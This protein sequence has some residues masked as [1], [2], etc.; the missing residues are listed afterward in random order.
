MLLNGTYEI[1]GDHVNQD[2]GIDIS[3]IQIIET[4]IGFI[5]FYVNP[6]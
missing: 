6:Y 4:S 3:E 2:G 1:Y 5:I